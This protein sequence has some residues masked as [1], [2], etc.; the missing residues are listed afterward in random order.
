MFK[1]ISRIVVS[2]IGV[3]WLFV[4]RINHYIVHKPF[5]V[6][7]ARAL[8]DTAADTLV[9]FAIFELVAMYLQQRGAS[10]NYAR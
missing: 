9:A 5:T 3:L 7:N 6:E 10:A 1:S 8:L 2:S 4:V